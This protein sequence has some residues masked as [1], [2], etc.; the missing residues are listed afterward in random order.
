[1]NFGEFPRGFSMSTS[2][3]NWPQCNMWRVANGTERDG[4]AYGAA[5]LM[6]AANDSCVV[7]GTIV[8]PNN[9]PTGAS[10]FLKVLYA[11]DVPGQP[12][13]G[14]WKMA[15]YASGSPMNSYNIM[16][17]NGGFNFAPTPTRMSLA[18]N[19]ISCGNSLA[20]GNR[21][22]FRFKS[23]APNGTKMWI[24]AAWIQVGQ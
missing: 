3:P 15:A 18:T 5:L 22:G 16:N 9:W 12:F 8:L 4:S 1:M 7:E 2:I 24:I 14:N 17:D 21:I 20:A 13:S 11:M 19:T 10:C 23:N 6:P